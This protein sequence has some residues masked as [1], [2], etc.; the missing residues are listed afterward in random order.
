MKAAV[1]MMLLIVSLP[2]VF[3]QELSVQKFYGRDKVKGYARTQDEFTIEVLAKIPGDVI[4]KEQVRLHFEDSDISFDSCTQLGDSYNCTFYEPDFEAYQTLE[5]RIELRDNA[6][7]TVAE[8]TKKLVIDNQAPRIKEASITPVVSS[9]EVDITYT[10]EDYALKYGDTTDCAGLKTVK[11]TIAGQIIAS[12]TYPAGTCKKQ[13]IMHSTLEKSGQVCIAAV[14]HLNFASLPKCVDAIVDKNAPEIKSLTIT[15]RYGAEITHLRKGEMQKATVNAK[16]EDESDLTE[17]FANFKKLNPNLQEDIASDSG[18]NGLYTWKDITVTEAEQCSIQIKATD[19]LE[20]KASKEFSCA[21]KADDAPPKML[22]FSTG[23]ERGGAALASQGGKISITFEDKDNTDAEGIG[24]SA[25][26]AYLDLTQL[27]IG[28]AQAD[29]CSKLSGAEWECIWMLNPPVTTQE[30]SYTITLTTQTSDD[31]GNK[32]KSEQAFEIIYDNTGPRK[33]E[34]MDFRIISG[35]AGERFEGGVIQGDIVQYAVR[36]ANFEKAYAN[37]AEI[38]GSEKQ[39]ATDCKEGPSSTQDCT[40]E[41]KVQINGPLSASVKF[42][43]YDDALNSARAEAKLEVYALE[44][45]SKADYWK[46]T[47]SITCT[48]KAV[49]RKTASLMPALVTCRIDLHTPRKDITTLSIKGP[50]SPEECTGDIALNV[51]DVYMTNIAEGSKSPYLFIRLMPKNFYYNQLNI[52]CPLSVY[53]KRSETKEGKKVYSVSRSAQQINA[54]ITIQFFNE[55]LELAHKNIDDKIDKAI[56][57]GFAKQKWIGDLRKFLSWI[58][59][60]CQIKVVITSVIGAIYGITLIF[61]SNPITAGPGAGFCGI[62]ESASEVYGGVKGIMNFLD[63][64]CSVANCASTGKRE[65]EGFAGGGV[66]WCDEGKQLYA[67]NLNPDFLK[68]IE[69][70]STTSKIKSQGG[71]LTSPQ[72]KDSLILSAG[73]LCLPGIISN[74]EKL[75]NVHCFKAVCLNDMV[76][77]GYPAEFCDDMSSY[78]T[79]TFVTGEIFSLLPFVGFVDKIIDMATTFI[80]DPVALFTTGLGAVCTTTCPTP[81]S[82]VYMA[83]ASLK[84]VSVLMEA[85]SSFRQMGDKKSLSTATTETQYCKRMEK[86]KKERG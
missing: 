38:G 70:E 1:M 72:I 59:T 30:D 22:K 26:Q 71:S 66:P 60:F 16:I 57:D 7:K 76:R 84:T 55:P 85:I 62:E 52:T 27:K 31:L 5:L 78:L 33:P 58:E 18:E 11:I 64:M 45:E 39:L 69:K 79:C 43:F 23:A 4:T 49:D 10:A 9:G 63:S 28:I 12:D 25:K 68:T 75:R 67:E 40:F 48:P 56:N 37:F 15:N 42:D 61:K 32:L 20:N 3:A 41:G 54:N 21:I 24:L 36:S 50:S 44:D 65:F 86:I 8:E 73:C 35:E 17:V 53:S 80:S 77:E 19:R 13:N 46:K 14:D 34:I 2:V 81:E 74:L 83:C 82:E 6:G 51:N 29:V 47:P